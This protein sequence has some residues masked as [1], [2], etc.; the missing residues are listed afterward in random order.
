VR[1]SLNS[2]LLGFRGIIVFF[3]VSTTSFPLAVVYKQ[4]RL[5]NGKE[6]GS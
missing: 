3:F 6:K 2:L 4:A 1:L 5:K